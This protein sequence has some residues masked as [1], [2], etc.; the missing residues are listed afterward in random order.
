VVNALV[1]AVPGDLATPTGGYA[2]DRRIIGEMGKLGW[3]V[4]VASLGGGF[5]HPTSEQRAFAA[6]QLS[7][8]PAARPVV[9]DGLAYGVLPGI[10]EKLRQRNPIVALVHHPLALETG[11]STLQ[12]AQMRECERAALACARRVIVTSAATA[13]LLA[14]D[15]GVAQDRLTVVLPG[16]DRA[17]SARRSNGDIVRLLSVGALVPR[18]GFDVLIAALAT[19][20]D[21]PWHLT[22]AGD[23]TRD[24]AHAAQLD[25]DIARHRLG[26]RV[27]VLGAVPDSRIA[28]LYGSS[29]VFVLA[30]HFEGYGMAFA[31]ALAHGLP[32]IGTT[33]G[34]IPDTVPQGAGVLV[35]P[36]D[37]QAMAT[38]LRRLIENPAAR[39]EISAC[40]RGACASLQSWSDSAKLFAQAIERTL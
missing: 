5:P 33:A 26:D 37:A 2:Y 11:L 9:V 17:A 20:T 30:S 4:Q 31:E 28:D 38:A 12:S 29:D 6:A 10:A 8:I 15:Y 27:A 35:P 19:L 40:A 7:A 18:K 32:V 21:L 24:P 23:R 13:R 14:S 36:D 1:F 39:H 25:S 22:V 34:A 16:T 3:D